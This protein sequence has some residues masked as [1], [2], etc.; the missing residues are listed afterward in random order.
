MLLYL[1][2]I[3]GLKL[4]ELSIDIIKANYIIYY[5]VKFY[6]NAGVKYKKNKASAAKIVSSFC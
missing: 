1:C 4:G 3:F 2:I 5:F 6:K